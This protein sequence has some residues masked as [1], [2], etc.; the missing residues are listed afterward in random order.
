MDP[1]ARGQE[2]QDAPLF[3]NVFQYLLAPRV[4][5]EVRVLMAFTS[6]HNPCD[7][8]QIPER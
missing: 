4:D 6:F 2:G 7:Y 5:M 8:H 3:N 1:R